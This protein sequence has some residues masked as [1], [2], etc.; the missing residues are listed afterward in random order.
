MM[1]A[2]VVVLNH[3]YAQ[4]LDAAITSALTQTHPDVEVIVIDDGSTDDSLAV[5]DGYGS[6]ITV[7]AHEVNRG[8]GAAINTGAMAASGDLV[9]FVD[10]DDA[11]LPEACARAVAAIEAEPRLGKFHTPLAIVD[12]EGR[13]AGAT[14]PGDPTGLADGDLVDHV[15][16][17]RSHG[18]PPMTGNAFPAETLRHI[19]PVPEDR[20][21]KAADS[22]LNEQAAICGPV[23]RSSEPLAAY[24]IHGGNQFAGRP[25]DLEWLRTKLARERC[26]HAHLGRV[27]ERLGLTGYDPDPAGPIDIALLGYRLASLRLDPDGHPRFGDRPDR[28]AALATRGLV[29]A[30]RSPHLP[31]VDRLTRSAWF[32]TMAA[33]PVGVPQLLSAYLPDGPL[34]P[35]WSRW[36]RRRSAGVPT[37]L[38]GGERRKEPR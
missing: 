20:Y 17:Y 16:R 2:S 38:V 7:L 32:A 35:I 33:T 27:S 24:R 26:S 9:W 11:L 30:V 22:F 28:R 19:L 8:Q 13:W 10:A 12:G 4:F 21:P 1:K 29:A 18:W 31:L 15:F 37:P 6:S 23:V 36:R 5:L 25:P 14:L 34:P 3:D